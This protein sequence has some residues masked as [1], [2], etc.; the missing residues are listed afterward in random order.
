MANRNFE[1][2]QTGACHR[3]QSRPFTTTGDLR[4]DPIMV[5]L[6]LDELTYRA[7]AGS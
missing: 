1:V 3:S 6:I 5:G 2:G 7:I 4:H